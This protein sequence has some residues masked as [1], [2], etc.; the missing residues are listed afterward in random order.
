MMAVGVRAVRDDQGH[1]ELGYVRAFVRALFEGVLR[2][3]DLLSFLLGLL[4]LLDML[5]PLWDRKRQTLHDK[6]AGSVVLRLRPE[7]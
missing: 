4:W 3:I 1:G 5:F 6:V 2:L 7:G